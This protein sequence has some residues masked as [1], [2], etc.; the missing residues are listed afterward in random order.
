[1]SNINVPVAD[2]GSP[3]SL[4]ELAVEAIDDFLILAERTVA[5]GERTV[6]LA[7]RSALTSVSPT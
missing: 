3:S 1:M 2:S 4:N 7:P 5:G 6:R